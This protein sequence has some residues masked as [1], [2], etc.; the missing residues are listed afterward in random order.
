MVKKCI[1]CELDL[2]LDKF[3]KNNKSKDGCVNKC[4]NCVK[5][6][7]SEYINKIPK[8]SC[9]ICN[10]TKW[11]KSF[12]NG[13]EICLSCQKKANKKNKITHKCSSCN[14]EQPINSFNRNKNYL[15]GIN[16]T[17]KKCL[18]KKRDTPEFRI[19]NNLKQKNYNK[20]RFFNA[21]A[22]TILNRCKKEK[23]E[24]KLTVNE[25]TLFLARQWKKQKGLC[26]LT[27]DRLNRENAAV[28]HIIPIY[29][30]GDSNTYN[31][32]WV[33]DDVNSIKGK[34]SEQKL[35]AVILKMCK[36]MNINH[37]NSFIRLFNEELNP[38]EWDI[39]YFLNYL[40][41]NGYCL[42]KS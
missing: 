37:I 42:Y 1:K 10:E 16:P 6:Y 7:S 36:T 15:T 34:L 26:A 17:C 13:S 3:H 8:I 18:S 29:E 22:R 31:L 21:R 39:V 20:K 30:G 11:L 40:K 25:L 28:D 38:D 4:K 9:L 41:L 27:G 33:I 2:S 35:N 14:L 19:K 32:R 12:E 23:I 5:K 24:C